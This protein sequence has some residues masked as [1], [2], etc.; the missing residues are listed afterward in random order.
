MISEFR[1]RGPNG[2]NDEFIEITN[3]SAMDHVVAPV[4]GTGY[5]VAASDGTVRCSIPTGTNI[6]AYGSYLCANSVGYSLSGAATGDA[7]YSTDIPDNAGIA[8]FNN[9][10]APGDL[11]LPNRL[12]AVGSTSEAN[13]L[14]KEGT[15]YPALTPFSIDYSFYRNLSTGVITDEALTTATPGVPEDTDDNATDF[16]FVDTNGTSAGAGQRL[17]APGPSNL[18][19]PRSNDDLEVSLLDQCVSWTSP[20]NAVR[21]FTSDPPQNATFGTTDIRRTI[22][23]NTGGN[24]TALRLRIMDIRT[25]PAPSGFADL[26]PRTSTDVVVTV[27]RAPCGSGTSNVTVEGTTLQQPPTQFNGGGFNTALTVSAI[28]PGT[29]LTAGA[30]IDVR[31]LLGMQQTGAHSVRIAVEA[32][33]TGTDNTVDEGTCVAGPEGA[34]MCD[35]CESQTPTMIGTS[36]PD[37]LTGTAGADVIIGLGGDDVIDGGGG[38]DIICG[39][40]GDDDITAGDGT[41]SLRGGPGADTLTA[42]T[43]PA[44]TAGDTLY[45]GSDDDT[46]IGGSGADSLRGGP[47]A[48]TLTAGTDP[49]DTAGDTLYGGPGDDT[50]IGGPGAD[51]LH[52]RGGA[53]S[54]AGE[55]GDDQIFGGSGDDTSLQGGDGVDDIRGNDGSDLLD[56]GDDA[57]TVIGGPGADTAHGGNGDDVL[58]GSDG[59]D[60]LN[61]DADHDLLRGGEDDDTLNGGDGDDRLYGQGGTDT[62]DGGTGTNIL[63]Q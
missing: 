49:A 19:S 51:T 35:V 10:I 22:T 31:L 42:G 47:G 9:N 2:A 53:D 20:P 56:G 15:G 14:F 41:D 3:V 59:T 1:V 62:L 48:D 45:G 7:T 4:S 11:T 25:F 44:D 23:N 29:P 18:A 13:T 38:N 8:L 54:V 34:A 39:G 28:T 52:G 26:R 17:G 16:V 60:T 12:D 37:T 43:D 57:D 63:V 61:G 55:G 36:G 58:K 6:P 32:I 27:D 21:D 33:T 5:A 40:D 46:L 50:L 30:S 24:V